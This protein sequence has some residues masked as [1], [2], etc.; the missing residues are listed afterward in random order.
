MTSQYQRPRPRKRFVSVPFVCHPPVVL[1]GARRS[2]EAPPAA[3]ASPPLPP[4]SALVS[5]AVPLEESVEVLRAALDRLDEDTRQEL[6][7]LRL[8]ARLELQRLSLQLAAQ[9]EGQT[10]ARQWKRFVFFFFIF[11][12]V[13]FG[14]VTMVMSIVEPIV[15]DVSGLGAP[16]AAA[17][18]TLV[19]LQLLALRW[20][21]RSDHER[22]PRYSS[23]SSTS[24]GSPTC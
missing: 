2:A 6:D 21:R 18:D 4:P 1:A 12:D 23:I 10:V 3:P 16:D 24:P 15:I 19:R 5:E 13:Q 17:L 11:F 20:A 9:V 8:G 7:T 14:V 22:V